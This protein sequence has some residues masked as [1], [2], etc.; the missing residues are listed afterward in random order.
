MTFLFAFE[1]ASRGDFGFIP[2]IVR[3]HLDAAALRLSLDDWR[4]LPVAIR[5]ALAAHAPDAAGSSTFAAAL[6]AAL[7]PAVPA[8]VDAEAAFAVDPSPDAV[9]PSVRAQCALHRAALPTDTQ[10]RALTPFAR[11][12]LLKLSRRAEPHRDFPAALAEL[13]L[14][15]RP[16]R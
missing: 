5:A 14:A 2:L 12:A 10:W 6:A 13:G 11:Y 7:S 8:P 9:P 4:K 1:P 16:G 15:G 3:F